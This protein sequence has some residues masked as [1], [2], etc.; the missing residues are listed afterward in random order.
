MNIQEVSEDLLGRV[1]LRLM[2]EEERERFDRL[3]EEEH[4]LKSSR[5]G[6]RHLRYVAEAEGQW[7]AIL[8]FSGAA[9]HLKAR[10]KW[11]RWSS[12]QRARRLSLVIN[13][14]RYLLLVER[15]RH[16]NLASKVLG[17][18]LERTLGN[19]AFGGGEFC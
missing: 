17:L 9:P 10:E 16:P 12:R 11:L 3:L 18:A 1:S 14:S 15:E 2:K 7:V 19:T 4:Y 5:I 13:N 8:S 6:G